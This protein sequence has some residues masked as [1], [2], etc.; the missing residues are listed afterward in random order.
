MWRVI[1][2]RFLTLLI[3]NRVV[4]GYAKST[5]KIAM[6]FSGIFLKEGRKIG[7]VAAGT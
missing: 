1:V 2:N 3:A 5:S 6:P 4:L 7:Q